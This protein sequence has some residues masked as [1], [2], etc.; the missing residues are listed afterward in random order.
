MSSKGSGLT[1][2]QVLA[3][4]AVQRMSSQIEELTN[5]IRVLPEA[6]GRAV[7]A[8]GDRSLPPR[9]DAIP[10]IEHAGDGSICIGK[11]E[12]VV[13]G[14]SYPVAPIQMAPRPR[15]GAVTRLKNRK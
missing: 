2:E 10:M 13:E 14:K 3:H 8:G 6:V 5:L 12:V 15:F 9:E 7:A 1:I 4:P 11:S